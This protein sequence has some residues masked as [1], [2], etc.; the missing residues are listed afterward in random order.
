MEREVL[1]LA[2]A[3]NSETKNRKAGEMAMIACVIRNRVESNFRGATTYEEVVRAKNQFSGLN[4]GDR[5]YLRNISLDFEDT[6]PNWRNALRVA[7][8]IYQT[9]DLICPV[10]FPE[11][12]RH[13]Y[14]PVSMNF[15][16]TW[17]KGEKPVQVI[18]EELATARFVFYDGIK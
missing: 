18:G 11:T 6:D 16:P 12:V 2:R 10:Y 8:V 17:A 15:T 5:N 7:E 3:V 14:S 13:F 1:W 9:G 4:F